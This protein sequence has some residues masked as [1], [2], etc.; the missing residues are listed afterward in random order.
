[1]KLFVLFTST[2]SKQ[3]K[4][5]FITEA[6]AVAI[7]SMELSFVINQRFLL[8]LSNI[9][10][11]VHQ[12][13]INSQNHIRQYTLLQLNSLYDKTLLYIIFKKSATS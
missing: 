8:I 3:L 5:D 12:L 11:E 9:H 1:M 2:F 13:S 4:E 10:L 6:I 7:S